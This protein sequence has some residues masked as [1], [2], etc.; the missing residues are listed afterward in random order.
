MPKPC[1]R[2]KAISLIPS[3]TRLIVWLVILGRLAGDDANSVCLR[4]L[5]TLGDLELHPLT[6][7]QRAV[8]VGLDGAVVDEYVLTTVY[9]DEAVALLVV[10]P[11]DAALCH[12]H[13]SLG[14]VRRHTSWSRGLRSKVWRS[15]SVHAGLSQPSWSF[16]LRNAGHYDQA[17]SYRTSHRLATESEQVMA[18]ANAVSNPDT[19]AISS[20]LATPPPRSQ[21][22]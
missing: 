1:E 15:T 17:R 9:G 21:L 11:L 13:S 6:F 8:A 5:R 14:A 4:T 16:V 18:R 22:P 3:R 20:P 7:F 19:M 10:E 12:V 2:R